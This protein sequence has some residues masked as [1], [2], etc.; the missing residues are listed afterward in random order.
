MGLKIVARE[1]QRKRAG[2]GGGLARLPSQSEDVKRVCTT[3]Y[4]NPKP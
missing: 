1:G 3:W 4:G 2:G